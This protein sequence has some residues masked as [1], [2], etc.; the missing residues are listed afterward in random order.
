M[1]FAAGMLLA[2]RYR[3]VGRIGMG[4]MS[5][6]WR[7]TD[8]L[9]DRPVAV[10][11]LASPLATDP[12]LRAGTRR[13]AMAAARLTHPHVTQVYDYGELAVAGGPP[14]PYLVMELV[15]GESLA[16]RLARGPLPWR[17]AV[18]MAA[19][20]AAGLAAAHR[21]GVV[22]RD[23][24]PGNVMLTATGAKI[25]DFG[26]ATL[27]G[28]PAGDTEPI[29][30]TP[31]YAAPERL[32]GI[33]GPAGDVYALGALLYEALTGRRAVPAGSWEE[34]AATHRAGVRPEPPRVPGLP[35]EVSVLCLACLAADPSSRPRMEQVATRLA[36]V[37]GTTGVTTAVPTVPTA[38]HPP[39]LID[40]SL[41]QPGV[42]AG[43]IAASAPVRRP[44]TPEPEPGDP[45]PDR[46]PGRFRLGA[47][48]AAGTIIA[49]ALTLALLAS[50]RQEQNATG[51]TPPVVADTSS[52]PPPANTSPS[53]SPPATREGV[54]EELNRLLDEAVASG[55]NH[56]AADELR[57][58]LSE[59]RREFSR[60]RVNERKIAEKIADLREKLRE[61]V[62]EGRISSDT[63]GRIQWLLAALV[64]EDRRG[65]LDLDPDD[66]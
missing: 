23:I 30:G 48:A 2:E 57:D 50:A 35:D 42:D 22:H 58:K 17:E 21:L 3:L 55:M 10:K 8:E 60:P 61:Y 65:G 32:S 52:A 7:A 64:V 15:V 14:V 36:A 26:I 9:L 43:R 25:L 12:D 29:I 19:Q 31:A 62:E 49:V 13:E 59:L 44:R 6:V 1:V 41:R 46:Q 20:V 51:A 28:A 56:K 18:R 63:A 39:T 5:E 27:T 24:K 37:I 33:A 45:A 54:V 40:R 66:D 4:G 47:L 16:D 38:D 34:A 11:A 53:P